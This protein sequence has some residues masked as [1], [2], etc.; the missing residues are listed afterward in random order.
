MLIGYGAKRKKSDNIVVK[1]SLGAK[2]VYNLQSIRLFVN[3]I[4]FY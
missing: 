2:R 4:L 1:S 3:K